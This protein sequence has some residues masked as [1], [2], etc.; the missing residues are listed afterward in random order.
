[1]SAKKPAVTPA[2]KTAKK[3]GRPR[4]T[5]TVPRPPRATRGRS[6]K[7]IPDLPLAQKKPEK[8][9]IS[10][11]TTQEVEANEEAS[12]NSSTNA[13]NKTNPLVR[14]RNLSKLRDA[15][16]ALNESQFSDEDDRV[17]KPAAPAKKPVVELPH[18]EFV[19]KYSSNQTYSGPRPQ[20]PQSKSS[21]SDSVFD[22]L[23]KSVPRTEKSTTVYSAPPRDKQKTKPE[24]P[25][26]FADYEFSDHEFSDNDL[27][28]E[29]DDKDPDFTTK[30]PKKRNYKP[31]KK[32]AAIPKS[33]T[34]SFEPNI[35]KV[36]CEQILNCVTIF[37][38]LC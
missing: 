31:R 16:E 38:I 23:I 2:P 3:R 8:S 21:N 36:N 7:D 33:S 18:E 37:M 12:S 20:K 6:K 10:I 9:K 24:E 19:R 30:L 29:D 17:F 32:A 22:N 35:K 4:K 1:V 34:D 5:D 14:K 27:E 15:D 11:E 25:K 13:A 26:L 28:Y